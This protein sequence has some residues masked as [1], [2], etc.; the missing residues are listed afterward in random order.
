MSEPDP[1]SR[2]RRFTPARV[3]LGRAGAALPTREVLRFGLA[4]AQ[5]RDA[6]HAAVDIAALEAGLAAQ[7]SPTFRVES[8]A[9]DRVTY[10]ARPDLGRRLSE[11]AREALSG[12]T[13]PGC[14]LAIVLADGLSATAI[15]RH[16]VALVATLLPRL[17]VDPRRSALPIVLATQAR[18][19]L[20]DEI[21]QIV[22][23]RLVL[24][25]I[26]ERPGLSAPDGIGAYLTLDPK[27]G[28]HDAERNCVS[29][30]RPEGLPLD[31]AAAK[32]AWL[33]GQALH[34]GITGVAL[35]DESDALLLDGAAQTATGALIAGAGS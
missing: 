34:R 7:G 4:H 27:P 3:A 16:A 25:L 31:L 9:P 18:V 20:G 14:D 8:A 5:A 12:E 23:A 33:V 35:K 1:W 22:R 29:N 17:A 6:V 10:L 11:R 24:V 21:G 28:R 13:W 30:I 19:A 15:D 2:I 32:I 26:G